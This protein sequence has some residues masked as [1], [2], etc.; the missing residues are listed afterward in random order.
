[1]TGVLMGT[2][3]NAEIQREPPWA[4]RQRQE[5]RVCV[6]RNAEGRWPAPEAGRGRD[7]CKTSGS[8]WEPGQLPAVPDFCSQLCKNRFLVFLSCSGCT[9]SLN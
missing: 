4:W 6:S 3:D 9:D 5:P 2:G 8:L 7:R 1:M